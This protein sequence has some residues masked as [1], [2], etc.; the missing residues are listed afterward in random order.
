[1]IRGG[2][3]RIRGPMRLINFYDFRNPSSLSMA[4]GFI[5]PLTQINIRS[6]KV[7]FLRSR[8]RPARK[9]DKLTAIC[10]PIPSWIIRTLVVATQK[11]S[12]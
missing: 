8:A 7:M 4:L 12:S 9:A 2:R 6:R 1:M 5:Q 3:S 11:N 10:E